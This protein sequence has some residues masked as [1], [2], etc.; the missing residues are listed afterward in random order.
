MKEAC[1]YFEGCNA[2]I[3]PVE[4]TGKAYWY[5][6][7]P[8]CKHK[9]FKTSRLIEN[10]KAIQKLKSAK[11]TY[12][13][14]DMLGMNLKIRE[15]LKGLDGEFSLKK[16]RRWLIKERRYREKSIEL[17]KKKAKNFLEE[18]LVNG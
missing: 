6:H 8:I 4:N 18:V 11:D 9:G 15:G 14:L 7:E 2:P 13:T 3:C 5:P 16:E 17:A 10:Q 12:F 1:P